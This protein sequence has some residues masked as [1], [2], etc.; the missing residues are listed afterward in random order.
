M[1]QQIQGAGI[2]SSIAVNRPLERVFTLA[3]DNGDFEIALRTHST[4]S[5][6]AYGF[7]LFLSVTMGRPTVIEYERQAL[8]SER[9]YSVAPT[10]AINLLLVLAAFGALA[11]FASQRT[12][13]DYLFLAIFFFR[14]RR[15]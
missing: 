2:R 11:L 7:P 12:Q 1:A 13:R 4:P 8:E 3:D 5:Y 15:F 9:M 14:Y 10:F 6:C